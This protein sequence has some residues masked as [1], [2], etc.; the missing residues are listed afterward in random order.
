MGAM[1]STGRSNGIGRHARA[2]LAAAAAISAICAFANQASASFT[3]S[4]DTV[5]V[6]SAVVLAPDLVSNST[7]FDSPVT[8]SVSTVRLSPYGSG[9][10]THAYSALE[11]NRTLFGQGKISIETATYNFAKGASALSL[12]W[13]SPDTKNTI[14]FWSG[15]NG[16][17]T[18]L[19]CITGGGPT[20]G[21]SGALQVASLQ[22]SSGGN[23]SLVHDLVTFLST[24]LFDSMVLTTTQNAFEYTSIIPD[25]T[26]LPAALPLYA[27]GMGVM[28]FVGWRRKRQQ[29][30]TTAA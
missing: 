15:L 22:H 11:I 28:G 24:G 1:F 2:V 19:F 27:A 20:T 14:Q 25:P 4:E 13:G 6:P 21:C 7:F 8:G 26:P 3:F 29:A 9:D 30:K 17:G 23:G 18:E 5:T 16:T 10:T 12:F